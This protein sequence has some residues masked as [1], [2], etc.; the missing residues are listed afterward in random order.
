LSEQGTDNVMTKNLR[1]ASIPVRL[2]DQLE[3]LLHTDCT[4][5]SP[6]DPSMVLSE[7]RPHDQTDHLLSL[8]TIHDLMMAP[9]Q[10]VGARARWSGHPAIAALKLRLEQDFVDDLDA[11]AGALHVEG[12]PVSA[13]RSL[14][15]KDRL[16]GV[17][18]WIAKEAS[19]D[20]L[21]HFIAV[22][23]GPDGGFDDLVALCQV[24]LSG[25]AKMEMARNYWDEMGN[26][27]PSSVHTDLHRHMADALRITA[28]PKDSLPVEALART[29]LGGVLATNRWLQPEMVGALGLIELQAGPRCR[30]VLEAFS[31]L[32]LSDDAAEFY[33]V[34]ADVDPVHGKDWL[35]QVI[36]PLAAEVP[37]WGPR[38]IRGAAWRWSV[39]A[40]LFTA[41]GEAQPVGAAA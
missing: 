22:E 34:H 5:P 26:G 6:D 14:A 27:V 10:R 33:A 38:M 32:G 40:K 17:Y 41:L 11:C 12:D 13:I 29:A 15:A 16:P 1:V 20:E 25:A 39:N 21:R 2:V 36:A 4:S 23:G 19:L 28:L 35:E 18:R 24:G 8:L 7:A 31:R 3:A 9:L 37:E 30:L